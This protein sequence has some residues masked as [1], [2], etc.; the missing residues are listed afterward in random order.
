M[1]RYNFKITEQKWQKYWEENKIFKSKVDRSKKKLHKQSSELEKFID[2]NYFNFRDT[3]RFL[4]SFL[5]RLI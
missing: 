1:T 5:T 2:E 3:K 4:S